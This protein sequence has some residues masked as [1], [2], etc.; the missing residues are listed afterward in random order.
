MFREASGGG[1]WADPDL[2][3]SHPVGARVSESPPRTTLDCSDELGEDRVDQA[4]VPG[5]P[6]SI[7][8]R[9]GRLPEAAAVV[10]LEVQ[11]VSE[12]HGTVRVG[13]PA[14]EVFDQRAV[15]RAP[16]GLEPVARLVHIARSGS[17]RAGYLA[18][19]YVH[20]DLPLREVS[21]ECPG[22]PAPYS[23]E[24]S[25][26]ERWRGRRPVSAACG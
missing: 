20:A 2:G 17:N 14:E 15:A 23:L 6:T 7:L 8:R 3:P 24:S 11:E 19:W 25:G 13:R 9:P 5:E 12:Q 10:E 26:L 1:L 21:L 18:C 4:F 16:G 22:I